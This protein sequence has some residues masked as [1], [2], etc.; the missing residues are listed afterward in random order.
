M[1]V[2]VGVGLVGREAGARGVVARGFAVFGAALGAVEEVFV[3]GGFF[4]FAAVVAVAN[5]AGALG[6]AFGAVEFFAAPGGFFFDAAA[7]AGSAVGFA[8]EAEVFGVFVHEDVG[9]VV[10]AGGG[11]EGF[12]G[13]GVAADGVHG[14]QLHALAELA[15]AAQDG[16][17]IGIA[18][19]ED[20]DVVGAGDGGVVGHG[21]GEIGIDPLVVGEGVGLFAEVD[22]GDVHF[23][24]A[25]LAEEFVEDLLFGGVVADFVGRDGAVVAGADDVDFLSG[26]FCEAL[27]DNIGD[28]LVVDLKPPFT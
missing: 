7:H 20:G 11:D 19:N 26:D 3:P 28:A 8:L 22:L 6:A 15:N 1:C 4:F 14:D 12:A 16:D 24:A 21:G 27:G 23:V 10:A 13:D 17:V 25:L 9:V 2:C 5:F 18:A